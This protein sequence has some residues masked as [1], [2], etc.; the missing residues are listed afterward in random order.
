MLVDLFPVEV[1]EFVPLGED[2][3]AVGL[4]SGGEGVGGGGELAVESFGGDTEVGEFLAHLGEGDLGVVDDDVGL[5]HEEVADDVDGGGLAGVVGVFFEGEAED[6]DFF[7]GDGVEEGLDDLAGEAGLLPVVHLD[8]LVPVGGDFGEAEVFAEVGEVEDVFLEAGAAEADGG[9]EEFGADA[10]VGADG[11][12][13]LV[14]VGAGAFA[15]GGDGVDGGDALGEEGVG[16]EFGEFGGPEV[17]GEDAFAG[18]PAGVDADEGFDGGLAFGG[19]FTADED[20]IGVFEVGDGGAFGEELGVGE[21]LEFAVGGVGAEDGFEGFGG[22]D[23]DGGFFDDDFG[24]VRDFGDGAGGEFDVAE[25][26]GATGTSAVGFGGGADGDEDDVGVFDGLDD[27]GAEEEVPAA[28]GLDDFIESG[29][30]DGE[31]SGVPGGDAGLVEVTDGDLDVGAF[32]GDHRHGGSADVA[33]SETT[34]FHE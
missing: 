21:D 29:F 32:V 31:G 23:G 16:D 4:V 18:N 14:D 7:A 34:D 13:D 3:D 17:G 12:G 1:A 33:G 27:V 11:A 9:F 20:A 10:G 19:G 30:V 2:G 5:F 22:F 26:G 6:G 25:V 24:A 8:D 28:G 15:E